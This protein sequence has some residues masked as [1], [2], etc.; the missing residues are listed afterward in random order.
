MPKILVEED[1]SST[2]WQS[3]ERKVSFAS[4]LA[5]AWFTRAG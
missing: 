5:G 1:V 2:R 4:Q 3:L